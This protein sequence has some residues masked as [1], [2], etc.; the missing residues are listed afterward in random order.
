LGQDRGHRLAQDP[1]HGVA[2]LIARIGGAQ[3]L[4]HEVEILNGHW[5]TSGD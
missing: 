2:T 1:G 3:V 4:E 5:T